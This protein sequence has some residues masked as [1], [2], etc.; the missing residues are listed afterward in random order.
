MPAVVSNIEEARVALGDQQIV[1]CPQPGSQ[2]LFLCCPVYEVLYHGTRGPG[3]TDALLMDFAQE[4]GK[5]WGN[6]WRGI[7]FR[8]TYPELGD[9][10]AKSKKWFKQIWPAAKFNEAKYQW[11]WPTGEVL[12]FRH[13]AK[14]DDYWAYHGHEYPFI[15]WEELTNYADDKCYKVMMSCSRST[16]P[17]MPR[18]YRATTNPYGVGHNWVKMRFRLPG[19]NGRIVRTPGEP[20]RVAIAGSVYE[21]KLLLSADPE[22][23]SKLKAAARNPSELKAW[24]EGS[25]DIVAGGMFD[26]IWDPSI[27]I[28]PDLP[29]RDIPKGWVI[30]RSFDYGES[31]PFS[32]G[33]WAQSNGEPMEILGMDGKPLRVGE[34]P[35]DLIRIAEWYG[36]RPGY[37]N[38]GLRLL[39]KDIAEGIVERET[40]LGIRKRVHA[41]PADSS[42]FDEHNGN[43]ISTDMAQEGCTWIPA[44]KSPGSRKQGWQ[45]LRKLLDG[46]KKRGR[47]G[48]REERGMFVTVRCDQF[49]RTF[50]VLPRDDKD[51]DDVDTDAEDHI[52]DEVRYRARKDFVRTTKKKF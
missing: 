32:V 15:G 12:M 28:I 49:Q 44:D 26:D 18:K 34:V 30:D 48:I 11:E 46:A 16:K 4:V 37:P 29:L 21:N 51:L 23:I 2:R 39:A 43:N 17:G 10:V 19:M 6:A 14:P 52:G 45:Q 1:W 20:D 9:V 7:I 50:P 40:I 31:K 38:E 47:N 3:K 8:K 42:I 24:L 22:Y 5:G 13:F 27:H 33:W 36:W 25:W 35:G 41:G